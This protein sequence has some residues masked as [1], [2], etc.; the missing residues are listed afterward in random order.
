LLVGSLFALVQVRLLANDRM[1]GLV[2]GEASL[3]SSLVALSSLVTPLLMLVGFD[4]AGFAVRAATWTTALA[5]R[6]LP[7]LLSYTLLIAGAAALAGLVVQAILSESTRSGSQSLW[8]GLAGAMVLVLGLMGYWWL[9]DR[10][11][12]DAG[13]RSPEQLTQAAATATLPVVL[14]FVTPALLSFVPLHLGQVVQSLAIQIGGPLQLVG[15]ALYAAGSVYAALVSDWIEAWRLLV[16]IGLIVMAAGLAARQQAAPA[17]YLGAVGLQNIWVHLTGDAGPLAV[18]QWQSQEPVIFGW[19]LVVALVAL[20]WWRRGELDRPRVSR[21]LFLTCLLALL[22]QT[23]F[24]G[25][26]FSPLLGFAGVG[27]IAFGIAWDILTAGGW[28]NED[29]RWFPR[30]SRLFLYVGYLL[31]TVTLV[32]WAVAAHDLV[33]VNRYTGDAALTGFFV[34]GVPYL[35]VLIPVTLFAA[36]TED[37]PG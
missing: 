5:E 10:A 4:I 31:L 3:E 6:L 20:A 33:S 36:R 23:N 28:A 8:P 15:A 37:R 35:Y 17:L 26:P 21:L 16:A 27:F 34:L 29:G 7:T 9:L 2:T 19:L 13:T 32:N 14:A 1:L 30:S 22:R 25:D 12:P 24:I 11:A 18:L